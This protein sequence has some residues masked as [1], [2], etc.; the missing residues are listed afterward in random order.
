[1][2]HQQPGSALKFAKDHSHVITGVVLLIKNITPPPP[3]H[4][5]TMHKF[6]AHSILTSCLQTQKLINNQ[7][8]T[9]FSH[10]NFNL[11]NSCEVI[12]QKGLKICF[13]LF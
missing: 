11:Y 13:G 6:L 1:M 12:G 3:P 4:S 2:Q 8:T 5:L 10:F 9:D 7:G